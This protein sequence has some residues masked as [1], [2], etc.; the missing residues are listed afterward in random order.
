[1]PFPDRS[2]RQADSRSQSAEGKYEVSSMQY[3][4]KGGTRREEALIMQ[5]FVQRS[6][7]QMKLYEPPFEDHAHSNLATKERFHQ[8]HLE[9]EFVFSL[10]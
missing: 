8:F 6:L 7:V 4:V 10:Q 5:E 9:L 2:W 1:M 3:L